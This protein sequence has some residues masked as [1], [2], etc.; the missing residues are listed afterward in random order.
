[1]IYKIF[2]IRTTYKKKNNK[3]IPQTTEELQLNKI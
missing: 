2:I 1:M 3:S